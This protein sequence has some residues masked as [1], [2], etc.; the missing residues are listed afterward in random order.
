MK[1]FLDT[2]VIVSVLNREYPLFTHA[3]QILSLVDKKQFQ[4]YTSP[5]CLAI[6]FYFSE[7][8]SGTKHA[9]EKIAILSGKLKI[10]SKSRN[11]QTLHC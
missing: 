1:I 11:N 8:K 2:N 5:L 3:A 7:K 4:V 6:A 10:P 9:K